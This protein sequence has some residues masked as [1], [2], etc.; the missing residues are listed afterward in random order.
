M[1][2]EEIEAMMDEGV[3]AEVYGLNEKALS[4]SGLLSCPFCGG[5]AVQ[6]KHS[7]N[8]ICE[9]LRPSNTWIPRTIWQTRAQPIESGKKG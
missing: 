6:S 7:D 8:V 5:E 4:P 2:T 9:C 3:M 1:E